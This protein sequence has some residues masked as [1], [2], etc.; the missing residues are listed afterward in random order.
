[1]IRAA[2][3]GAA[4][5][6]LLAWSAASPAEP[7]PPA[8]PPVTAVELVAAH[9]LPE[10]LVRSAIVVATGQPR[11]RDAVRESLARLWALEL[12]AAVQVEEVPDGGGVRLRFHLLRKPWVQRIAWQGDTG[13]P[14]AD[15][16][17]AAALPLGGDAGGERLERAKG[18]LLRLLERRGYLTAV[19]GV[20]A[21]SDPATQGTAVR[22]DIAAGERARIHPLRIQGL[23]RFPAGRFHRALNLSPG[24]RYDEEE[25]RRG[26]RAAEERMRQDGFYEAGVRLGPTSRDPATNEVALT[27]AVTEGPEY[28]VEFVGDR[29]LRLSVL[30]QALPFA[31]TGIVDAVALENAERLL[32]E[33][34]R[35]RG[36]HFAEVAGE[37]QPRDG[38]TTIRFRVD[39]GPR[40]QVGRITFEGNRRFRDAQLQDLMQSRPATLLRSGLFREALLERDL[41]VLLAFYRSQGMAAAEVGP[42][43]VR[44][45]PDRRTVEIGIPIVEGERLRVGSLRVEGTQA[46]SAGEVLAALPLSPGSLWS[47]SLA[48]EVRR[49]VGALYASRGHPS[50]DAGVEA[51]PRDGLVDVTVRVRE[52]PL[53]RLG[54]LLVSGLVRTREEVVRREFPLEAAEPYDAG[55]LLTAERRLG[56]LGIFERIEM[57]PVRPPPT[58]FTDVALRLKEARPWRLDLGAGYSTDEGLRGSLELGHDNLFG[59]ARRASLRGRVSGIEDSARLLFTEPRLLGGRWQLDSQLYG[60]RREEIGYEFERAGAA[61]E[62]HREV[63]GVQRG[64]LRA[65]LRYRAELVRRSD[66]DP[67][68]IEAAVTPGTYRIASL[69]PSLT[70]DRRNDPLSP[71]RGSLYFVALEAAGAPLGSEVNFLKSEV[72]GS[73]LFDWPGPTILALSARVGL[74]RTLGQGHELPIEERFFAGGESTIRG[75]KRNRVG[76]LDQAGHPRGGNARVVLNAEWRFPI[77]RFVHGALFLDTG[78]VRS[79]ILDLRLSEFKSGVGGG[80]RLLTPVG[81]LRFDVGYGLNPVAGDETRLAFYFSVG[82]PF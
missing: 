15:L 51:Q 49:A 82:Y 62:V 12:F 72:A 63:P 75:Y 77:W 18:E 79:E 43:A 24:Q 26:I 40:V 60:E 55:A 68:L 54:R 2:L 8:P 34:Y 9:P 36:Y 19:V 57:E 78:T 28:R 58:P 33:T 37:R 32:R 47:E 35:E 16:A 38:L 25:V 20:S 76:P 42:P 50:A 71:T 39:P 31:D 41:R 59:T 23:S 29:R 73:W 52:G 30:R 64:R 65:A 48:E 70:L 80:V 22:F 11:S 66:V 17:A 53:T 5:A 74:A 27:I 14:R 45:S 61:T 3:A 69:R 13:L 56:D 10:G 1:M 7:P 4:A 46:L 44:F 21:V 6:L 81:P 67:G